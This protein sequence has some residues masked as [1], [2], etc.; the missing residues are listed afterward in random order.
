MAKANCLKTGH[1]EF[2]YMAKA[3]CLKTGHREIIYMANANCL[4]TG[5]RDF[6]FA[7]IVQKQYVRVRNSMT[8]NQN[9]FLKHYDIADIL[10]MLHLLNGC[11]RVRTQSGYCQ[12]TDCPR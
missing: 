2:I 9:Y 3:N 10:N 12:I 7:I 1:R 6:I 11:I 5:H 8:L 4:K